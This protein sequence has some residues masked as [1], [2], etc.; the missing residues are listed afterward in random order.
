MRDIKFFHH[1]KEPLLYNA[2]VVLAVASEPS[3]LEKQE[4]L[5]H[6][7]KRELS[8]QIIHLCYFN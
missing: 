5:Q 3:F 4:L 1:S 8:R 6:K 7:T 2:I